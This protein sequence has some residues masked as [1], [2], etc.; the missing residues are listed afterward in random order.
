MEIFNEFI[1]KK[2]REARR[3][4]H[5]LRQIL[6]NHKLKVEDYRDDEEPYIYV[7]APDSLSF[8]GIRIYK[9]ANQV[10]FRIQREQKTHPYGKAYS[11]DIE[12]M[13]SDYMSDNIEE[14]EAGKKV[15]KSLVQ[16]VQQF[17]EKSKNAEQ[18]IKR[19]E[20]DRDFLDGIVLRNTGTD[21]ANQVTSPGFGSAS[22]R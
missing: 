19:G 3:H 5:I 22:G 14:E 6:E 2:Q 13:F 1:D 8:G 7:K 15:M 12:D 11:L 10:A 9:V 17:F 18:K 20:F 16:E 4:L 21:Y